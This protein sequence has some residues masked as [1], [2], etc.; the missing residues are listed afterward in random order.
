VCS[1]IDNGKL[2]KLSTAVLTFVLSFR[3]S[4]W[5]GAA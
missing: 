4:W 5:R 1:P 3:K 2:D